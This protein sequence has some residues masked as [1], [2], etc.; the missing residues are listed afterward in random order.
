MGWESKPEPEVA[1]LY[2]DKFKQD[3]LVIIDREKPMGD[4]VE[5]PITG[6]FF[7]NRRTYEDHLKDEGCEI[8]G[9]DYTGRTKPPWLQE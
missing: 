1:G 4:G 3:R 8:I 5:S 6:E 9:N 7:T 2:N